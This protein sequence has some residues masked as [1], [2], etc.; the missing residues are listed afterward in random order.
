MCADIHRFS[1]REENLKVSFAFPSF[2]YLTA[3]SSTRIILDTV[4][5]E[6]TQGPM[7]VDAPPSM[8]AESADAFQQAGMK[9]ED[10]STVGLDSQDCELVAEMVVDIENLAT[11]F[12]QSQHVVSGLD[13]VLRRWLD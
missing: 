8:A 11:E 4:I 12:L 2:V 7:P 13:H 10:V 1:A 9:D 3:M 5:P 6:E